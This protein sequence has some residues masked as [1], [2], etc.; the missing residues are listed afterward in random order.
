[1]LTL[2]IVKMVLEVVLEGGKGKGEGRGEW[3]DGINF[4]LKMHHRAYR[5]VFDYR[6][7]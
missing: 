6:R 5:G 3:T 2:C 1:M 4:N 7:T